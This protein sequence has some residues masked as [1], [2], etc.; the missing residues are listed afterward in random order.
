MIYDFTKGKS[1][2]YLSTLLNINYDFHF[3]E[4]ILSQK[5]LTFDEIGFFQKSKKN[6]FLRLGIFLPEFNDLLH[7]A[8]PV[9]H[10]YNCNTT[11]DLSKK[12]KVTN[13]S[14]NTFFSRDRKKNISANLK[15]CKKCTKNL[16]KQFNLKLLGLNT[17][18]DFV[19]ALE[20]SVKKELISGPDGYTINWRQI[21]YCYRD[22]KNFICEKCGYQA[23][24]L[25][26]QKFLHTHHIDRV[27]TNNK[28]NNLQ[29]LCVK[30]HSEVDD[31]HKEKFSFECLSL[32]DEFLKHNSKK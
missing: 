3:N 21:S 23:K 7:N 32:L 16:R 30:C 24:E 20:E 15:I 5:D 19:L 12:M 14:H 27:K 2:I 11:N 8:N 26:Q 4:F 13:S 25:Y 31:F 10:I 9:L 1:A 22:T 18:N 6:G 28:R 17:F 29:C